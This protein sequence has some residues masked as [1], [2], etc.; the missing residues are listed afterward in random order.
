L[1]TCHFDKPRV[2]E[3][4]T[5]RKSF[6]R[7]DNQELANEIHNFFGANFEFRVIKVELSALDLIENLSLILT[8]ERQVTAHEN[9]EEASER[10]S[11]A[12]AVI[13]SIENLRCHIVWSTSDC[14]KLFLTLLSLGEA[15]ID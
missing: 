12:L 9:I 8:L 1:N 14:M 6:A 10:P 15:K 11:I 13:S 3:G 7:F 2:L 5:S 4:I